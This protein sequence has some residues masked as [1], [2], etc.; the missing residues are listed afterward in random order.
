MA[1]TFLFVR[2]VNICV[3]FNWFFQKVDG[4]SPWWFLDGFKHPELMNVSTPNMSAT[5]AG[6]YL[7]TVM[8]GTEGALWIESKIAQGTFY[9]SEATERALAGNGKN[10]VGKGGRYLGYAGAVYGGL[11]T[12]YSTGK[13]SEGDLTKF[14]IGF[15]TA[16]A[17]AFGGFY[18]ALDLGVAIWTGT[19]ITD[20][21]GAGVDYS[22]GMSKKFAK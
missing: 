7:G 2:F 12:Y 4:R 3:V 10:L 17:G 16:S 20:R 15:G 22:Y 19:S 18:G 21:V 13:F 8:A 14:V 5:V 11:E 6:N 9:T 1:R